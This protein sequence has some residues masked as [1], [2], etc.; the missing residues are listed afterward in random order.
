MSQ[1]SSL[2]N[3][4]EQRLEQVLAEYLHAVEAGQPIDRKAVLERNPDLADELQSFFCNRDAI[5]QLARPL[6]DAA[7]RAALGDAP[8]IA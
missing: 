4:R 1:A 3:S 5:D 2:D 8:T 7:G 6:Q